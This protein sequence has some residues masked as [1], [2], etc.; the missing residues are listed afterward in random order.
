LKAKLEQEP[1]Q[2]YYYQ[3][4]MNE[5]NATILLVDDDTAFRKAAS[6]AL[7][8]RSY[9]VVTAESGEA[10]LNLEDLSLCDAAV[11][12][13]R[14]PGMDGLELLQE[15]KKRR[16]DLPVIVLTGHGTINT[17]IDAIKLEAF[18]YLTKPCDIPE[19]DIYL[20]KAI[21]QNQLQKENEY[22]RNTVL[23][24]Q[25]GHGIIGESPAIRHVLKLIDRMKDTDAPVLITG[26]SGTG[27]ELVAR[28]LHFQSHRK[29]QPFIAVNCAT[30]KPELLENELFGHVSGAFTGAVSRK[31]GLLSVANRG[32]LFIDEIADMN[33]N[34]QASL[35]RVIETG[36][37]RPLG[38]TR[39]RMTQVRII[40]AANRVLA[41]EVRKGNFR[42]DLFY[43][44]NVLVISTPP[45]RQ[46]LED[47]PLL[48]EHFVQ[49][50]PS[51]RGI[52]FTSEAIQA[53]QSYHWQGN[54]RELLNICERAVIL[55]TEPLI[56]AEAIQSLL[57]TKTPFAPATPIQKSLPGSTPHKPLT[58][59]EM[60]KVHI[61]RTLE[62]TGNNVSRTAELLGIDR[63]TLQ[64]KMAKYGLRE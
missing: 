45:L 22:L 39:T 25:D 50:S 52:T 48:V 20:R 55:S 8:R 42:E 56:T 53:L 16:P 14:M 59:D 11:I 24:K 12:D 6:K 23:Q 63:R 54:V 32:T 57:V 35:L 10:A 51:A 5:T 3:S 36:E 38:S 62:E 61:S 13:L 43:R 1:E 27:K 19:L 34:V 21:N 2:Q 29:D 47:I 15:L 41:D 17:A 30:L 49:T 46:H 37:Y 28:A 4:I 7:E 26:E 44:L 33:P 40:A 9:Q 64:R 31:E 58:L 18:H 60:E